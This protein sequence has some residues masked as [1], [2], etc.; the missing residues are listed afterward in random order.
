MKVLAYIV[1]LA[2]FWGWTIACTHHLVLVNL[3]GFNLL[4]SATVS[5]AGFL[6]LWPLEDKV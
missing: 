2:L 4:V 6:Y 3:T 5:S 1:W